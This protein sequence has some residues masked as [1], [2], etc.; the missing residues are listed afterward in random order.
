V[1]GGAASSRCQPRQYAPGNSPGASSPQALTPFHFQNPRLTICAAVS[2][3]SESAWRTQSAQGRGEAD[4]RAMGVQRG[5]P[6]PSPTVLQAPSP[7]THNSRLR[8]AVCMT[9]RAMRP[10]T[11]GPTNQRL[12]LCLDPRS[13]AASVA[14]A[15]TVAT[16]LSRFRTAA[17]ALSGSSS[18]IRRSGSVPARFASVLV[19]VCPLAAPSLVACLAGMPLKYTRDRSCPPPLYKRAVGEALLPV[20]H[21]VRDEHM[22]SIVLHRCVCSCDK[23][24]CNL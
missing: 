6:G 20:R 16:R 1:H 11:I 18:S 24:V 7:I 22:Q 2:S 3:G 8:L 12:P 10:A 23:S 17:A 21:T 9:W 15:L 13:P 4:G 5:F 19:P 14:L